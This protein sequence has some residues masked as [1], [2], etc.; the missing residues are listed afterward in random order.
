VKVVD[1]E[2]HQLFPVDPEQDARVARVRALAPN[3]LELV[4][5][6]PLRPLVLEPGRLELIA[7]LIAAAHVLVGEVAAL[8]LLLLGVGR[9][10]AHALGAREPSPDVVGVVEHQD[11]LALDSGRLEVLDE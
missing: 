5:R 7:E 3:Q 6:P 8:E 9:Q 2:R 10:L 11:G 1:G 4:A